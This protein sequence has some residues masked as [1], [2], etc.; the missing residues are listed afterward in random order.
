M[1][2]FFDFSSTAQQVSP[3]DDV[4]LAP[5]PSD[6]NIALEPAFPWVSAT[7]SVGQC[8]TPVDCRV[9]VSIDS[10]SMVSFDP[11]NKFAEANVV[12]NV[13][14]SESNEVLKSYKV[15]KSI[16]FDK[17]K[18]KQECLGK[19]DQTA[20][21]V[22]SKQP[23]ESKKPKSDLVKNLRELAGVASKGNFV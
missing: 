12:L 19:N 20:P 16:L 5:V 9:D 14:F 2:T 15:V 7:D 17:E 3:A 22:E 6:A 18:L 13:S 1:S 23:A 4:T 21:V 11:T 8:N 10:F